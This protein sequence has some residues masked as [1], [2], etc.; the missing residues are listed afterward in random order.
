VLCQVAEL[1]EQASV[2]QPLNTLLH[3][4]CTH[5]ALCLCFAQ[6]AEL[7]EQAGLLRQDLRRAHE[8]VVRQRQAK[9]IRPRALAAVL[10]TPKLD[11]TALLVSPGGWDC[12]CAADSMYSDTIKVL[13]RKWPIYQGHVYQAPFNTLSHIVF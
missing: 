5:C 8:R 9:N 11:F 2:K 4:C 12:S 3:V 1:D 6:V 7:G 13:Q 10:Q